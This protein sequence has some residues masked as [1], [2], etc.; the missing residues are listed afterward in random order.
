MATPTAADMAKQILKGIVETIQE[1]KEVPSG[2]L[3]SSLTNY[4]IDF[5]TYQAIINGMV[6]AGLIVVKNNVL[7]WVKES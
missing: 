5:D 7:I 2:P 3:Y 1:L 4:G 6:K